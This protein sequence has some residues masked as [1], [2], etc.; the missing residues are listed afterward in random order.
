MCFATELY[1]N[2]QIHSNFV[3][4]T[5]GFKWY[6]HTKNVSGA[7]YISKWR[8]YCRK[9]YAEQCQMGMYATTRKSSVSGTDRITVLFSSCSWQMFCCGHNWDAILS[10]LIVHVRLEMTPSHVTNC[11]TPHDPLPQRDVGLIIGRLGSYYPPFFQPFPPIP[12]MSFPANLSI[13]YFCWGYP[14]PPLYIYPDMESCGSICRT[15]P[16]PGWLITRS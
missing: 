14:P 15:V 13:P 6:R 1:V 2:S 11:H 9:I 8:S 16:H 7:L 4:T 3:L 10:L 12:H 5:Q